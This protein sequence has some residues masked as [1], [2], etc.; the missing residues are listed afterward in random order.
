M[1]APRL[2]GFVFALVLASC[3]KTEP[4]ANIRDAGSER[5]AT[6]PVTEPPKAEPLPRDPSFQLPAVDRIVAIGDL[7]G[8]V[9]ALRAA[10]R[11]GG[12]IDDGGKWIGKNL[13]VVQPGDQ[14][15]RGDDEPQII[16]LF[17]R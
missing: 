5:A 17:A 6:A 14:L 10:L 9:S 1:M 15:A 4:P 12:A 16:E 2:L 7:H 11:L 8:D 13:V 3:G